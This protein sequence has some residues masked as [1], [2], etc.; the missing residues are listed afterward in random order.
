MNLKTNITCLF[1]GALFYQLKI[2]KYILTDEVGIN[3]IILYQLSKQYE[4]INP[5]NFCF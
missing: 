5:C 2:S 1:N 3:A 4:K